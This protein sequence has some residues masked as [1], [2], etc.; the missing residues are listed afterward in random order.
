MMHEGKFPLNV[1]LPLAPN[2]SLLGLVA[3]QMIQRFHGFHPACHLTK[4][5][6]PRHRPEGFG[7]SVR[8]KNLSSA[9]V[10]SRTGVRNDPG[11]ELN[12]RN[13]LWVVHYPRVADAPLKILIISETELDKEPLENAK[14]WYVVIE[15]FA[16]EGED[17]LNANRRPIVVKLHDNGIV[18]LDGR[19]AR[20]PCSLGGGGMHGDVLRKTQSTAM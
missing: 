19:A 6:F 14:E 13:E 7:T 16:K 9:R 8:Y 3:I 15:T 1:G 17:V 5:G 4:R 18:I 20:H 12:W 11:T 2:L 10:R